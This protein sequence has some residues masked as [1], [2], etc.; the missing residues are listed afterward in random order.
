MYIY[1]VLIASALVLQSEACV[2]IPGWIQGIIGGGGGGGSA[3][4]IT[5]TSTTAKP[6]TTT[7]G[8]PTMLQFKIWDAV[9][10]AVRGTVKW[11]KSVCPDSSFKIVA[12]K[13]VTIEYTAECGKLKSIEGESDG[14]ACEMFN[15]ETAQPIPPFYVKTK[16][17]AGTGNCEFAPL[18][19]AL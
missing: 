7:E 17:G 16:A 5:M 1:T 13:N 19:P 15:K 12:G 18:P 8:K 4:T 11:E 3:T 2:A 14:K 6:T 9:G 10:K